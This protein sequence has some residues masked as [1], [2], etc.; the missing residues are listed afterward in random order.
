M[1][2][3]G[4]VSPLPSGLSFLALPMAV[5]SKDRPVETCGSAFLSLMCSKRP[6]PGHMPYTWI[7]LMLSVPL[8]T[9]LVGL[10]LLLLRYRPEPS[11]LNYFHGV[12]LSPP[13]LIFAAPSHA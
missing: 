10:L 9:V 13:S 7:I 8:A 1:R 2:Q 3:T 12:Q 4:G 11:N 6:D 5:T